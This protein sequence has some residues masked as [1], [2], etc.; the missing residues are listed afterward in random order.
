[1]RSQGM[2]EGDVEA[3]LRLYLQQCSVAVSCRDLA[4][5]GATLA[6]GGTNPVSGANCLTRERVRDVVSVMHT[7]GMYDFAGQWA[8][9]VGLPAKSGVS[10]A[11]LCVVPGKIGIAVF[12]P[13]L[14]SY[15]NSVRG[16]RVCEEISDRLGLHVFATEGEDV[17]LRIQGG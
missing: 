16:A 11:I 15:G 13:G 2:I 4:V 9:E 10:G 3:T 8:Y 1:M 17:M 14:D 12:S 6:N 5:M 7:C